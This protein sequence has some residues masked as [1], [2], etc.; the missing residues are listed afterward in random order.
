ME[1]TLRKGGNISFSINRF[2]DIADVKGCS[3][4]RPDDI[5]DLKA[6]LPRDSDV[7]SIPYPPSGSPFSAKS[8]DVDS[9]VDVDVENELEDADTS[10]DATTDG[11]EKPAE[12]KDSTSDKPPYSYNALIMMA[13]RNSADKKLTLNG[14]YEFIMTNFPYYRKNKQGWQNSIRHNLSLNKCFVKVPRHYDDPGKGN[15]WMLDP[16]ADDVYIGGTTGKLRRRSTSA[17]RSRLAA[18]RHLGLYGQSL[19]GGVSPMN[20]FAQQM[21]PFNMQTNFALRLQQQAMSYLQ[22]VHPAYMG[23]PPQSPTSPQPEPM[24]PAPLPAFSTQQQPSAKQQECSKFSIDNILG[25][26]SP[27]AEQRKS[28]ISES[29]RHSPVMHADDISIAKSDHR[30]YYTNNRDVT[31]LQQKTLAAAAAQFRAPGLGL[32]LNYPTAA[33]GYPYPGLV[34]PAGINHGVIRPLPQ[35]LTHQRR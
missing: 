10:L 9:D 5:D 29:E 1:Q 30:E 18:L 7:A 25:R 22:G 6:R 27:C 24:L 32:P 16:S 28:P 11:D 12:K 20:R 2:L 13:I 35:M 14:I 3:G 33:P 23:A 34:H 8:D 19:F 4:V 17:S 31:A 15:Y 21:T 26:S